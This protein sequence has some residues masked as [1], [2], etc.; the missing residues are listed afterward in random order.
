MLIESRKAECHYADPNGTIDVEVPPYLNIRR[1]RIQLKLEG[2]VA[3]TSF[4]PV[5]FSR[6]DSDCKSAAFTPTPN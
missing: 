1:I 3:D 4:Q 5:G 6:R 2:G